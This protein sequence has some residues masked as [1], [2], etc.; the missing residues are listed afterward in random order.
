MSN[1]IYYPIHA[2]CLMGGLLLLRW[3]AVRDKPA[4]MA[5]GV[6]LALS[7]GAGTLLWTISEPHH[8][9]YADF[10]KAYYPAGEAVWRGD[11]AGL[12]W[13]IQTRDFVNAPVVAWLFVPLALMG[14]PAAGHVFAG[15]GVAAVLASWALLARAAR[16]NRFRA[17]ALFLLFALSGPLHYSF[18]EGNAT[19]VVFLAVVAAMLLAKR[20]RDWLAGVLLGASAVVKLPLLLFG[21]YYAARGRWRVAAGGA[22]AVA[23]AGALSLGLHGVEMNLLWHRE[24]VAPFQKK[25]MPAYNVQS[26]QGFLARWD[27]AP[28]FNVAQLENW[29]PW[30]Y[31]L[32]DWDPAKLSAGPRY[33]SRFATLAILAAAVWAIWGRRPNREE[34]ASGADD[35]PISCW[36]IEFG[37]VLT[38][39]LLLSPM[40][41]AHYYVY[42]LLPFALLL[43]LDQ[44]GRIS[45][46]LMKLAWLAIILCSLPVIKPR[47]EDKFLLTL[48]STTLLSHFLAGG[49]LIFLVLVCIQGKFQTK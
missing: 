43:G 41:W 49:L 35:E 15:L 28:L 19:H 14:Q 26:I 38:L 44:E 17:A 23:V 37:L 16:L 3:M 45:P 31:M 30:R 27:R 24:C 18:R 42:L 47:I 8:A 9:L 1:L 7:A 39:T 22:L 34:A 46:R 25:P 32:E 20:R 10:Y 6:V 12:S 36:E 13:L 11:P 40:T 29:D 5:W 2:A 4:W 48:F 21:V 33:L